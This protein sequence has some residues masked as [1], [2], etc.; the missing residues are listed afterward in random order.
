MFIRTQRDL[1]ILSREHGSD[2]ILCTY[3]EQLVGV[4]PAISL[5]QRQIYHLKCAMSVVYSIL[6]DL[7]GY[8]CDIIDTR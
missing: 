8:R 5:N 1:N 6:S 2:Q 4:P 3:C 7:S